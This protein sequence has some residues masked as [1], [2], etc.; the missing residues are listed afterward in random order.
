MLLI[1]GLWILVVLRW[2]VSWLIRC[3]IV[4]DR[5]T[6][7]LILNML[8]LIWWKRSAHWVASRLSYNWGCS[9]I[10]NCD[11]YFLFLT[12]LFCR[13]CFSIVNDD[14]LRLIYNIGS[15]ISSNT[16]NNAQAEAESHARVERNHSCTSCKVWSWCAVIAR[17]IT[18]ILVIS[19][20]QLITAFLA[21][22]WTIIVI[23]TILH[24]A[25]FFLKLLIRNPWRN[26]SWVCLFFRLI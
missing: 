2:I 8:I 25:S 9:W 6:I 22:R 23:W 7:T 1:L 3:S 18:N 26:I 10:S 12:L 5:L 17:I 4:I 14:R 21:V 16:L 11:R 20:N 19:T 24:I 13:R 15:S